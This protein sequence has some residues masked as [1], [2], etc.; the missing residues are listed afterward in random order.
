MTNLISSNRVRAQRAMLSLAP[1]YHEGNELDL[2][3][4][5]KDFLTDLRH[6]CQ[7]KGIDIE[8]LFRRSEGS[9]E[10]ER[11]DVDEDQVI[12][13]QVLEADTAAVLLEMGSRETRKD[14]LFRD[15]ASPATK[16]AQTSRYTVLGIDKETGIHFH[17]VTATDGASALFEA[18]KFGYGSLVAA[19]VGELEQAGNLQEERTPGYLV[20]PPDAPI[21]MSRYYRLYSK[22]QERI[23][24]D[25]SSLT[26]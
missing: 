4:D 6:L 11:Q 16:V 12:N 1:F 18:S 10:D 23:K 2:Q 17:H 25:R 26:G 9:F 21:S 5:I 19:I 24:R 13:P 15:I 20:F 7:A 22:E 14:P 3:G 8:D